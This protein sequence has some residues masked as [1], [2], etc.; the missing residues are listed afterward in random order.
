MPKVLTEAQFSL[1][2]CP[3]IQQ[4]QEFSARTNYL[5]V[6]SCQQH[7][8]ACWLV[9]PN[10]TIVLPA[11]T[12]P[13]LCVQIAPSHLIESATRLKIFRTGSMLLF[14]HPHTTDPRL[15]ATL[16]SL[17]HEMTEAAA[18]WR[19]VVRSLLA[20]LTVQILRSHINLKRS[21][22]LE[23][24][25]VGIVDRRLRRAMEFMHDHCAREL[26]LA[27]IA[28][29]AFLSEFHFARLFKK[30][31]GTTPH[32]YLAGLRIERAR[33]LLAETD[34]ALTEVGAQVGY[35]SQSHFT[36]IFRAATGLT[37]HAFR[38]AGARGEPESGR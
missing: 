7:E 30:I 4:G 5:L 2:V 14:A 18:G 6:F 33:Q 15:T 36:K 27:E 16:Q 37:P 23:L 29:A 13:L 19:E 25:R 28:A 12:E 9:N 10:E 22:E 1:E 24:S 20:Q 38:A 34:L 11:T 17:Y 21:E 26:S 35:Q 32:A 3:P 31:T 8:A